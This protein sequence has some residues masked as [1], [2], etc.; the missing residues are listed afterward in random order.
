MGKETLSDASLTFETT[1]EGNSISIAWDKNGTTASTYILH[2]LRLGGQQLRGTQERPWVVKAGD[3]VTY[4]RVVRYA[5]KK[6]KRP[7][8]VYGD[9]GLVG[10]VRRMSD[11]E[12]RERNKIVASE[13]LLGPWVERSDNIPLLVVK[14]SQDGRLEVTG[15]TEW[16][17]SDM[18]RGRLAVLTA[19]QVRSTYGADWARARGRLPSYIRCLKRDP[20]PEQRACAGLD[21]HVPA[22]R[23]LAVLAGRTLGED[24]V[25]R[26]EDVGNL[27]G[28]YL[29][30]RIEVSFPSSELPVGLTLCGEDESPFSAPAMVEGAALWDEGGGGA[31]LPCVKLLRVCGDAY[32]GDLPAMMRVVV[33][34]GAEWTV[35]R[36]VA[37]EGRRGV[38]RIQPL[39][40]VGGGEGELGYSVE[41]RMVRRRELVLME[42]WM[43]RAEEIWREEGGEV[44][45]EARV[46]VRALQLGLFEDMDVRVVGDRAVVGGTATLEIVLRDETGEVYEDH[47]EAVVASGDKV[48]VVG[49]IMK[50]WGEWRGD[51]WKSGQMD[52]VATVQ[53]VERDCVALQLEFDASEVRKGG[54]GEI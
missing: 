47:R 44:V 1:G 10:L 50:G 18:L 49:A 30:D 24:E 40:E 13:D 15:R 26:E 29:D 53:A 22:W 52:L 20:T 42:E 27:A 16:V 45:A 8:P 38:F 28:G 33:R 21:E 32:E 12:W 7:E 46:D 14:A 41:L 37:V 51:G 43:E 4:D 35:C 5:S 2:T 34:R 23:S 31:A 19:E 25:R 11:E 17:S 3:F 9:S 54:N 39:H 6:N 48:A 36:T